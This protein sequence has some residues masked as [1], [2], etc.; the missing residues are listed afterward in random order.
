MMDARWED[1]GT[2]V[3]SRADTGARR[4]VS[5]PILLGK[6]VWDRPSQRPRSPE[7]APRVKSDAAESAQKPRDLSAGPIH[8]ALKSCLHRAEEPSVG[9][10]CGTGETALTLQAGT[11]GCALN[12]RSPGG[13]KRQPEFQRVKVDW[14]LQ[15]DRAV[16]EIRSRCGRPLPAVSPASEAGARLASHLLRI[17]AAASS[18]ASPAPGM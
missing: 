3:G 10:L 9:R 15:A 14:G 17:A 13:A 18:R 1:V 8:D 11:P 2:P 12:L 4:W 5:E 7:P 6:L 16:S